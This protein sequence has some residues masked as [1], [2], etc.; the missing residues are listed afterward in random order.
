MHI[1][2]IFKFKNLFIITLIAS[3]FL[4]WSNRLQG[5]SD[6]T[7]TGFD[8]TGA[9]IFLISPILGIVLSIIPI[10]CI[11]VLIQELRSQNTSKIRLLTSILTIILFLI[12]IIYHTMSGM[13]IGKTLTDSLIYQLSQIRYG[14]YIALFSSI[15]IIFG[16]NTN[17][18]K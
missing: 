8:Y 6:V 11:I 5:I 10:L 9:M 7:L 2:R 3:F 4:P 13:L 14:V 18:V 16:S 15:F 17:K 12:A 1:Q